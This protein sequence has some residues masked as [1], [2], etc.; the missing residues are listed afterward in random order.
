MI[1]CEPPSQLIYNFKG[2]FFTEE[3]KEMDTDEKMTLE[4]TMW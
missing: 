3:G 1:M 2:K 4:N